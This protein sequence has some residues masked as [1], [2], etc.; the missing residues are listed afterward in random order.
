M[1]NKSLKD[2][3]NFINIPY[4]KVSIRREW[5]QDIPW[6]YQDLVMTWK[7]FNRLRNI[8]SWESIE[9]ESDNDWWNF[10]FEYIEDYDKLGS[11]YEWFG[12]KAISQVE[13]EVLSRE[14]YSN[15]DFLIVLANELSDFRELKQTPQLKEK[16]NFLSS[17]WKPCE[18]YNLYSFYNQDQEWNFSKNSIAISI[19]YDNDLDSV[20]KTIELKNIIEL[21]CKSNKVWKMDFYLFTKEE[22]VYKSQIEQMEDKVDEIYEIIND[23]EITWNTLYLNDN[24]D[25]RLFDFITEWLNNNFGIDNKFMNEIQVFKD[26]II[27]N[28]VKVNKKSFKI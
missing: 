12:A 22:W 15:Y 21:K 4:V 25:D 13:Y 8:L 28:K 16:I 14:S 9:I 11:L 27:D 1:D 2:S 24:V 3:K 20:K 19:D 10:K 17:L 23:K 6:R 7:E 26:N 18:K 5:F